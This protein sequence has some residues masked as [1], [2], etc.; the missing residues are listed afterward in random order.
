MEAVE[1]VSSQNVQYGGSWGSI[2]SKGSVWMQLGQCLL[3]RFSM[4]AVGAVS[5]QKFQYG[6][7]CSWGFVSC[8]DRCTVCSMEVVMG[9]KLV[10]QAK[11]KVSSQKKVLKK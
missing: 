2:F 10:L 8:S 11:V 5:S 9:A 3:K 6:G 7:S 1:V 4:E